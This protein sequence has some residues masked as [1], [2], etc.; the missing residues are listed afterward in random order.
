[1]AHR[2]QLQIDRRSERLRELEFVRDD[3]C[4]EVCW[5]VILPLEALTAINRLAYGERRESAF[6]QT[7]LTQ[8]HR[9]RGCMGYRR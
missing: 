7:A 5:K 4:I 2:S 8:F 6:R 3:L 1:M 9:R